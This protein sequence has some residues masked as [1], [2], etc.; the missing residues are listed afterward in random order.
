MPPNAA[1]ALQNVSLVGQ[2]KT[3]VVVG[4]TLGIGAGVA[5]LLA[6]IGCSRVFIL[7]RDETR[8]QGLLEVLKKLAPN[9][10]QI[11]VE[12]IKGDLS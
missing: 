8:G 5:R 6:K 1:A 3:A 10:G 11:V 4:G 12:F 2:N 9:D 7:G